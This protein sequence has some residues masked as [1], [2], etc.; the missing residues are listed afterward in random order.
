MYELKINRSSD[1]PLYFRI[2]R[3]SYN[4]NLT[5]FQK[6]IKIPTGRKTSKF[7][8]LVNEI[9]NCRLI[10]LIFAALCL[11]SFIYDYA[12]EELSK[13]YT[14]KYLDKLNLV[15]KWVIIP[16]LVL[17]RELDRNG[18]AYENVVCLKRQ[19]DKIVH[20]KS[21]PKI[22]DEELNKF[23]KNSS[24]AKNSTIREYLTINSYQKVIE[25]F[26]ELKKLEKEY[27]EEKQIILGKWWELKEI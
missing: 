8:K 23:L 16:K 9:Q 7:L 18:Q 21:T 19:R 26:G 15:A 22:S 6:L 2:C 24:K 12:A 11:E 4:N 5:S 14:N 17:G 20:S 3:D 27:E 25:V 10:S 1:S 13:N